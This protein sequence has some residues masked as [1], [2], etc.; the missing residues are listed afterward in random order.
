MGARFVHSPLLLYCCTRK[1]VAKETQP[2]KPV[3]PEAHVKNGP[4][5]V[6]S[7]PVDPVPFV[8]GAAGVFA[9]GPREPGE[10]EGE[11]AAFLQALVALLPDVMALRKGHE[12]GVGAAEATHGG[13]FKG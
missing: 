12:V 5:N 3:G 4:Q 11:G 10:A 9:A 6:S 1:G 2:R 8:H 7:A 13:R